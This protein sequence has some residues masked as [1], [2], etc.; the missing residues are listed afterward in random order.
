VLAVD[1]RLFEEAMVEASE[2]PGALLPEAARVLAGLRLRP[3][4]VSCPERYQPACGR[5][6]HFREDH[7]RAPRVPQRTANAGRERATTVIRDAEQ[8]QQ[9]EPFGLVTGPQVAS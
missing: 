3:A 2:R 5:Q 6:P 1:L 9:R 8:I 4:V 7:R